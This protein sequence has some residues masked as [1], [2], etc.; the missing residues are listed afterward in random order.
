MRHVCDVF[1]YIKFKICNVTCFIAIFSIKQHLFNMAHLFLPSMLYTY[2]FGCIACLII[3]YATM[4]SDVGSP[5]KIIS[6][7]L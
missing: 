1:C 7:T 4:Y 5:R 6:D 3:A 2:Q